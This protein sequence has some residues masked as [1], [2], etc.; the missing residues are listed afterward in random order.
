MSVLDKLERKFGRFAIRNLTIYI[1]IA[2]AI[3]YLTSM[4]NRELYE[5]L[6]MDPKLIFEGQ[7][8]RLFTWICTMPQDLSLFIIFMFIF[9][10]WIGINLEKNWGR[11]KYN[12]FIFSGYFFMTI[13]ALVIYA[14]TYFVGPSSEYGMG[15]S[16]NISTYYINLTSFLAFA[17]IYGEVVIYWMGIL[18][19][20]VKW[21]A[22]LDLV[23]I[24]YD[25]ISMENAIKAV[26]GTPYKGYMTE[27]VWCYR[28]TVIISLLNFLIFYILMKKGGRLSPQARKTRKEFKSKVRKIQPMSNIHQCEICGRTSETDVDLVFRYCSKCN[29]NHEYCQDHLFTH[30]H[31]K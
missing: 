3:G 7:V 25:M 24:A 31:V 14:V 16:V 12:L 27:V 26:S 2:Y 18:P 13:G 19:I 5:Y 6:L 15:I 1:L 22:I 10:Y 21:L 8:W 4:V 23:L 11:F 30:P 20:K 29:G 28:I 17:T 9:F